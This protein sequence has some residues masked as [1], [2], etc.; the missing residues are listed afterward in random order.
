M[1]EVKR[2]QVDFGSNLRAIIKVSDNKIEIKNAI[3]GWGNPVML[4]QIKIIE[5]K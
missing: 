3:D 5:M 1:K 4:S 2:Y